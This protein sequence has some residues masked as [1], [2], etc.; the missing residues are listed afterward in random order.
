MHSES[1]VEISAAGM[2][3]AIPKI[4]NCIGRSRGVNHSREN[5]PSFGSLDSFAQHRE[6]YT[7][8]ATFPASLNNLSV[9][10]PRNDRGGPMVLRVGRLA[11]AAKH[12]TVYTSVSNYNRRIENSLSSLRWMSDILIKT[13]RSF[14]LIQIISDGNLRPSMRPRASERG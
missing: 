5:F 2:P 14:S 3:Y 1:V 7:L 11:A 9:K 6:R 8:G 12:S 10:L 4:S 13:I